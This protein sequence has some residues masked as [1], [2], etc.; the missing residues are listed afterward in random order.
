MNR[1]THLDACTFTTV[2][3]AF[4]QSNYSYVDSL[5]SKDSINRTSTS[6]ILT[7]CIN[8]LFNKKR[9]GEDM[10]IAKTY[11]NLI[12]QKLIVYPSYDN[13]RYNHIFKRISTVFCER[14]SREDS[15]NFLEVFNYCFTVLFPRNGDMTHTQDYNVIKETMI[16]MYSN[17]MFAISY[18]HL[19][20]YYED[21]DMTIKYCKK[22]VFKLEKIMTGLNTSCDTEHLKLCIKFNNMITFKWA[23]QHFSGSSY[24]CQLFGKLIKHQ[25]A[26]N[27]FLKWKLKKQQ[28]NGRELSVSNRCLERFT[29]AFKTCKLDSTI[30]LSEREFLNFTKSL[31]TYSGPVYIQLINGFYIKPVGKFAIN[32][33]LELLMEKAKD[34]PNGEQNLWNANTMEMFSKK[35]L[36]SSVN[37]QYIETLSSYNCPWSKQSELMKCRILLKKFVK[38]V[39]ARFIVIYWLGI[40]QEALCGP[41]GKGRAEDLN[42]IHSIVQDAGILC[43]KRKLGLF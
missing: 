28:P 5:L 33:Y 26:M 27:G 36:S 41:N 15:V 23:L 2:V 38:S 40:T 43:K 21:A 3:R 18:P 34:S 42:K 22:D 31:S 6:H 8:S 24:E 10:A 32:K 39:K 37:I 35:L 29:K 20:W 13:N 17:E 16:K 12:V 30:D 11:F 1:A 4:N 9:N 25:L 14:E 7:N 19:Y